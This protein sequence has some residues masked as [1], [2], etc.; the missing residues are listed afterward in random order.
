MLLYHLLQIISSNIEIRS[1]TIACISI[2]W[3]NDHR[4][5]VYDILHTYNLSSLLAFDQSTPLRHLLNKVPI[6]R[7]TKMLVD[8]SC[9]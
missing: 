6:C 2:V 8:H 7:T 1:F 3:H 5:Q 9:T 4:K